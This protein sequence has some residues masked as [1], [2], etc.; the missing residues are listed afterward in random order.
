MSEK[1]SMKQHGSGGM[2]GATQ[3]PA[4]AHLGQ[5]KPKVFDA[6]GAVGHQFTGTSHYLSDLI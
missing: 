2:S 3:T 6:A 4:N 1:Y 5:D